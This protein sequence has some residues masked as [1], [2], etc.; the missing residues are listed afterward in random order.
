MT[1]GQFQ[2]F[3]L[4]SPIKLNL[5]LHVVGQRDD[6]YH[7]LDSLVVFSENGDRLTFIP[8]K[9]DQ[10]VVE[11]PFAEGLN[12][13]EDN[14]IVRARDALRAAFPGETTPL[15][16]KLEKNLPL[17]SGIG[18][19]SGD[20][21]AA[22]IGL[23]RFWQ[24]ECPFEQ[25]LEIGLKLGADVPMCLYGMRCDEALSVRGIGEEIALFP[26]F[27]ALNVVLV[28]PGVEVSTPQIFSTLIKKDNLPITYNTVRHFAAVTDI[29]TESRNDLF[30]P[31]L[32]QAPIIA[33]V[34]S[35]LNESG[36]A[37]SRMSGSGAT[38]FGVFE[39]I[40]AARA[41]ADVLVTQYPHW[42]ILATK[43][44]GH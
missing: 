40:M 3:S 39:D 32:M 41:A 17:S 18:G 35:A 11:G 2:I 27:P 20:A 5:A 36:A 15:C 34:L 26:N 7:L 16:I 25:L 10:F 42:F 6:G 12:A 28:N 14:L 4:Y 21:A 24:L 19:G 22:L 29:L 43:T 13:K 44:K 1:F 9:D 38:C 8:A 37:F 33:D 30:E 23:C 31:A